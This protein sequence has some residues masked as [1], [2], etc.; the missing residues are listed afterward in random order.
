MKPAGTTFSGKKNSQLTLGPLADLEGH[1]PRE[2]WRDLFTSLYLKTDGDVVENIE[3]TRKEVD[4]L[5]SATGIRPG[6]RILDLC[7]GQGRHVIELAQRGFSAVSGIDRSPYLIRTA[8]KRARKLGLSVPFREGDA[9]VVRVPAG[10]LDAVCMMGNSFGYFESEDDDRQVLQ[11]V[12][13]ALRDRGT[14]AIDISDGE[15]M[16]NH[17]E[18]RSWEWIDQ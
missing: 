10:S 15:W 13:K 4:L 11:S 14:F 16:R 3:A 5:I 18:P 17:F 12:Q 1:L 8:R 7:C 9:R 6:D 2:W